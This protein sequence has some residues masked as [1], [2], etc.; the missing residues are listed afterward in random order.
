MT[1]PMGP[2]RLYRVRGRDDRGVVRRTG[3]FATRTAAMRRYVHWSRWYDVTIEVSEP[4]PFAEVEPQ[5][6]WLP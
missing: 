1:R 5:S 4:V 2:R 6:W 3:Y